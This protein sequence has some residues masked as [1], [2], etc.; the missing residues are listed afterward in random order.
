MHGLGYQRRA[1]GYTALLP[2]QGSGQD[3]VWRV[4]EQALGDVDLSK[5]AQQKT[6][7]GGSRSRVFC[8]LLG[9]VHRPSA[10][11]SARCDTL[12]HAGAC[13]HLVITPRPAAGDPF[14]G[15]HSCTLGPGPLKWGP[16]PCG[17][18]TFVR[19]LYGAGQ[20][21]ACLNQ[22]QDLELLQ[23]E[24]SCTSR[25]ARLLARSSCSSAS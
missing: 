24:M 2:P 7:L 21:V 15:C 12:A 19:P 23:R 17:L 14:L 4:P 10:R 1:A 13:F 6:V 18:M 11:T 5:T 16:S 25:G 22:A 8:C 20:E 3:R 9:C